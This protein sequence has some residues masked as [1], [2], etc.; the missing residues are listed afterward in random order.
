MLKNKPKMLEECFHPEV[1]VL[2]VPFSLPW[3]RG[4]AP[5]STKMHLGDL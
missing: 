2:A 5:H 1:V 4:H 3:R